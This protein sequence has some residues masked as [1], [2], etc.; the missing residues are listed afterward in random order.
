MLAMLGMDPKAAAT[1]VGAEALATLGIDP[2]AVATA[3]GL[4]VPTE[5]DATT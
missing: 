1:A 3:V 4:E 5:D 2:K